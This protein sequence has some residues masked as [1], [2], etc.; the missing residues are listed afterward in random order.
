MPARIGTKIDHVLNETE[1][2]LSI[3]AA[4]PV[5]GTVAGLSKVLMGVAQTIVGVVGGILTLPARC[6]N[7][8][9][10]NNHFWT[11][12]KHG[13][14][15]VAAGLVEA[16]P[17]VGTGIYIARWFKA[18]NNTSVQVYTQTQHEDKFMPYESLVKRDTKIAGLEPDLVSAAQNIFE[19]RANANSDSSHSEDLNEIANNAIH[20]APIKLRT[21]A[22]SAGARAR[23][24]DQVRTNV[25]G[26]GA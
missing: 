15:N 12:A 10:L 20:D 21:D 16:I 8:T 3:G 9:K 18:N 26:A 14:G 1:R 2:A 5:A 4:I 17:L 24:V 11:H 22:R 19:N 23:P 25:A 7:N 13:V 6:M